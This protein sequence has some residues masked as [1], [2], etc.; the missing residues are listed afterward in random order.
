MRVKEKRVAIDFILMKVVA[1]NE[2]MSICDV[3]NAFSFSNS[4]FV[5]SLSLVKSVSI[6][7]ALNFVWLRLRM[8]VSSYHLQTVIYKYK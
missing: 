4:F 6:V 2:M 7:V 1:G 8:L 3:N 5:N